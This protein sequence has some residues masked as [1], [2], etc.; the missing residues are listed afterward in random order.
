MKIVRKLLLLLI[1]SVLL[2][3]NP[4]LSVLLPNTMNTIAWGATAH[5]NI[6]IDKTAV[7]TPEAAYFHNG[8]IMIPIDFLQQNLG[9]TVTANSYD[10]SFQITQCDKSFTLSPT[11]SVAQG[12]DFLPLRK[13]CELLGMTIDWDN[14]TRT[15][16]IS[17]NN[18][19]EPVISSNLIIETPTG[20]AKDSID[21]MITLSLDQEVESQYED[22]HKILREKFPSTATLSEIIQYAKTKGQASDTLP[23]KKWRIDQRVISVSSNSGEQTILIVIGQ[24]ST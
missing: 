17:S 18:P 24:P 3:M 22:L 20:T 21:I 10:G 1:L 7:P 11:P 16:T 8:R 13:V 5:F 23:L 14:Q 6:V 2:L 19:N 12:A 15:V 9:L 4:F